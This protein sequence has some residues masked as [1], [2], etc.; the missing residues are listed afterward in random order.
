MGIHFSVTE[1]YLEWKGFTQIAIALLA[2]RADFIR[3]G[4]KQMEQ[5]ATAE[6]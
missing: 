6:T 2:E 3:S 1:Q 4:L 5:H